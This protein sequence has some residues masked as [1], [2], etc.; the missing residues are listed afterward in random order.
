MG[1]RIKTVA[2]L[3]GVP[4]STLLAWERR[5]R[6]VQPTR[7]ENGYREYS[8]GDVAQL[9]ALKRLLDAGHRVGE[10]VSLL[11]EA[12][13]SLPSLAVDAEQASDVC[14]DV[15]E[16]LLR[17]DRAGAEAVLLRRCGA[18]S[19]EGLIDRIYFPLLRHVGDLWA[20]EG[21]SVAQEHLVSQFCRERLQGMLVCLDHGPPQGR[22][23]LCA[24]FPTEDHDL[25]LLG[26]AVK[27]ALRSHRV[28]FLGARVPTASLCEMID[29]HRPA[30]V[31]LSLTMP[32][33][34]AVVLATARQLAA[35]RD[36]GTEIAIGG[37]GLP[38]ADQLPAIAGVRWVRRSQDLFSA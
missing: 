18:M 25:P 35:G 36:G 19:F 7:W 27:L 16:A 3:L 30:L 17:L 5:Y 1:Y 2:D 24:T 23:T 37:A 34:P 9:R 11:Q 26:L 12:P 29:R 21:L 14:E 32:R 15:L 31:C 8:E 28:I 13:A 20:E 4:R 33:A 6:I 38:D 10:A 22:L